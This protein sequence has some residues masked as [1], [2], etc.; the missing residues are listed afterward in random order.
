M[1]FQIVIS[2]ICFAEEKYAAF[3]NT[4][5]D[6]TLVDTKQYLYELN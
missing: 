5:M 1:E 4:Y 2:E 6:T 3:R